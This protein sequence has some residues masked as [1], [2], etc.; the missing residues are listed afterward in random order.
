MSI[1]SRIKESRCRKAMAS[2]RRIKE[3]ICSIEKKSTQSNWERAQI[4][5]LYR[6]LAA[7]E[8]NASL[9]CRDHLLE[10][11]KEILDGKP[12]VE[13]RKRKI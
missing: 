10:E 13:K 1:D 12:Q 6:R 9:C 8:R 7:V 2:A 5:R 11:L 3:E 4:A